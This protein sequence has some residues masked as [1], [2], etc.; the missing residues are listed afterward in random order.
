M[1]RVRVSGELAADN[2][3]TALSWVDRALD[4]RSRRDLH[5]VLPAAQQTGFPA[6]YFAH[7]PVRGPSV[8]DSP[9]LAQLA[10]V[11]AVQ[12]RRRRR[13]QRARA[14]L[15]P[16][17]AAGDAGAAGAE[18]GAGP[19]AVPVTGPVQVT[20]RRSHSNFRATFTGE[21]VLLPA[22]RQRAYV[23]I[24]NIG[25][26]DVWLGFDRVASSADGLPLRTP[27]GFHELI[28]GTASEVRAFVAAGNTGTV[29][30]VE[31]LH[32][33]ALRRR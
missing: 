16:D 11:L 30:V 31:G 1:A 14:G 33:P 12:A 6:D 24:V 32:Y 15:E 4:R 21:T 20:S 7:L 25:A 9:R 10:R 28:H 27:D 13:V 23:L 2:E 3:P 18:G 26:N 19:S 5:A 29:I 22:S 8:P 17:T